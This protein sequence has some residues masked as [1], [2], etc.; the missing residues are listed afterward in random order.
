M[1]FKGAEKMKRVTAIGEGKRRKRR[2]N[3][4]LDDKFAFSLEADVARKE[5]LRVGQE[6]S[7]GDIEAL[8]GAE[9]SQRCLNTALRYL[10]Y[11][12]RSEAELKERLARRGFDGEAIT[13][14]LARLKEQGLVDDLAFAQF[15]KENRQ[16]FSP[17]SQWL[18]RRELKAKGV[19]EELIARV[20]DVDDKDSAYQ[21]AIAKAHRLP[22]SDYEGFRRRLGEY[23]KRRGFGYGVINNTLNKV[24]AEVKEGKDN[25]KG[26]EK[27][28]WE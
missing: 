9:L 15:W 25:K 27:W 4:F 5:G 13:T 23:L 14:T 28:K 20:A 18:V 16:S 6:L 2:V 24:W 11:R 22:I 17:R 10:D 12:P 7:E 19:A 26:G 21:A 1:S 3:I 8:A